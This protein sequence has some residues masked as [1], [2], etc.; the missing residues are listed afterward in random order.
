MFQKCISIVNDNM[1]V[2]LL[3]SLLVYSIQNEL[4][5]CCT[6][7]DFNSEANQHNTRLLF[8]SI[9]L[10][11]FKYTNIYQSFHKSI[12]AYCLQKKHTHFGYLPISEKKP[13]ES[14]TIDLN[15]KVALFFQTEHLLTEFFSL[16]TKIFS[17]PVI[18]ISTHLLCFGKKKRHL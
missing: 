1:N 10:L 6:A 9:I 7:A 2:K 8:P 12:S 11:I 16:R 15:F 3:S 4:H 13:L 17:F 14:V 18:E 5:I